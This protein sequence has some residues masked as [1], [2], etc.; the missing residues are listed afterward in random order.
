MAT[1]LKG[2]PELGVLDFSGDTMLD[3]PHTHWESESGRSRCFVLCPSLENWGYLCLPS[4]LESSPPKSHFLTAWRHPPPHHS[5][6]EATGWEAS[7]AKIP[8]PLRRLPC[9]G[10]PTSSLLSGTQ[11]TRLHFGT[12]EMKMRLANIDLLRT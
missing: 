9:R 6:R 3:L 11:G 12:E 1:S 2:L 4:W 5:Q 10:S 7:S 8:E